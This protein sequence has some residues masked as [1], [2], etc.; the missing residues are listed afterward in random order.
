M[1]ISS[2]FFVTYEDVFSGINLKSYCGFFKTFLVFYTNVVIGV[3]VNLVLG[4][5]FFRCASYGSR[6]GQ[7]GIILY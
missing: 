4:K 7:A 5:V 3:T 1:G 6:N 2:A